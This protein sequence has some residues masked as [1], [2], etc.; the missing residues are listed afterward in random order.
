MSDEERLRAKVQQ[1][2]RRLQGLYIQSRIARCVTVAAGLSVVLM[3]LHKAR[4][5]YPVVGDLFES[6]YV[7]AGG[8]VAIAAAAGLLWGLLFRITP[9]Q[10]AALTDKRLE[11]RERLSSGMCFIGRPGREALIP[12][13]MTDAGDAA[14]A[15]EPAR[16]YP[17]RLPRDARYLCAAGA[18]FAALAFLPQ[19]NIFMSTGEVAVRESMK[20]QAK[21]IEKV[22]KQLAREA[23]RKDLEGTKELAEKA[24]RLA[25][26]LERA[27]LSKKQALLKTQKLTEEIRRKQEELARKNTPPSLNQALADLKKLPLESKDGK[28]LAG[29]LTDK[30]FAEAAAKLAEMAEKLEKGDLPAEEKKKLQQD[31]KAMAAA[32]GQQ[33]MLGVGKS[34]LEAGKAM[35]SSDMKSAAEKLADSSKAAEELAKY[36]AD[37]EAMQQMQDA[38][39]MA[40]EMMAKAD[41][42]CPECNGEGG[43]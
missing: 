1:L 29:Q 24:T 16:V 31:L 11:L 15:I 8:L 20:Q 38:M 19:M 36:Q 7:W 13:L 2:A 22:A 39:K 41:Q 3:L 37:A 6:V 30:N 18:A 42:Q 28:A 21:A 40:Q 10:A 26:E 4:P 25:Q 34:L 33:P 35:S 23:D 32:L 12:E 43:G 14:E 17:Y 27:R 9:A 5:I